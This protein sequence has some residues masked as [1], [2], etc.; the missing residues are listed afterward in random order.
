MSVYVV[1]GVLRLIPVTLLV[2]A[3]VFFVFRIVP[4]D[5]AVMRLGTTTSVSQSSIVRMVTPKSSANSISVMPRR[6]RISR[7][8]LPSRG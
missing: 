4:G 7:I 2:S 1:R 6:V 5:M 8:S 3:A